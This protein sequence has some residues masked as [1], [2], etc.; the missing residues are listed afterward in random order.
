MRG[1]CAPATRATV[2]L[3]W[4][5]PVDALSLASSLAAYDSVQPAIRQLQLCRRFGRGCDVS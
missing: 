2:A 1:S 5:V 4:A 3:T